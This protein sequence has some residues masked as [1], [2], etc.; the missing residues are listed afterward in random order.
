[1]FDYIP[2]PVHQ[3]L[4]VVQGNNDLYCGNG[5]ERNNMLC[6]KDAAFWRSTWRD[7]H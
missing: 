4:N 1:V 3:S 7:I 6:G 2:F 5:T